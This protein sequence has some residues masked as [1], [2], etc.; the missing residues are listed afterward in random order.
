MKIKINVN[1]TEVM[2]MSAVLTVALAFPSEKEE[3][4]Y[5]AE[6]I[7]CNNLYELY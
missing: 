7:V 1:K 2:L 5:I 6:Q 4:R 3:W